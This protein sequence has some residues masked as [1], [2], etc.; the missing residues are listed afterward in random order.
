VFE[1][2]R[3]FD[4]KGRV[5]DFKHSLIV[6]TSNVGSR[7]IEDDNTGLGFQLGRN[8]QES[9]STRTRLLSTRS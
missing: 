1:D 6:L 9:S 7:V 8:Y 4:S 3:L 5:V 2:G